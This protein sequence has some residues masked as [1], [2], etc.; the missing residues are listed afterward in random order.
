M[1]P[2]A[3]KRDAEELKLTRE[4]RDRMIA[5][6]YSAL[7]L[8]GDPGAVEGQ[9]IPL[10]RRKARR[11]PRYS[12]SK[13]SGH[14]RQIVGYDTIPEFW[15][16]WVELTEPK[17]HWRGHWQVEFVVHDERQASRVLRAGGPPGPPQEPGL[18]TRAR[19]SP[20]EPREKGEGVGSFTDETA[21]GYGGGGAQA[22]DHGGVEDDE[23]K[24]QRTKSN[25]RWAL[26]LEQTASDDQMR[27]QERAVREQLK[28]VIRSKSL[29]N[30][31]KQAI[32]AKV[33]QGLAEAA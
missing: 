3:G 15:S 5:G 17:R 31:E 1:D 30:D 29:S 19:F 6:D 33:Q 2:L 24:R 4:Q 8:D 23:L 12:D 16:L 7:K 32:L 18:R 27:R 26:H 9:R 10:L 11:V 21:R 20:E 28:D 13:F 25:E 14:G 22:L